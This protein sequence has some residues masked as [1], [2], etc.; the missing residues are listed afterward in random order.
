MGDSTALFMCENSL[1]IDVPFGG[2]WLASGGAVALSGSAYVNGDQ[3]RPVKWKRQREF[4][5][6]RLSEIDRLK[7]CQ[8]VNMIFVE[9][10]VSAPCFLLPSQSHRPTVRNVTV[11]L[12]YTCHFD[13]ADAQA[14]LWIGIYGEVVH[15]RMLGKL[16]REFIA[17]S[18][19]RSFQPGDFL[20]IDFG[21]PAC[22]WGVLVLSEKVGAKVWR[23]AL[24]SLL[25]D[26]IDIAG[27]VI[28]STDTATLD[29]HVATFRR[30][31][32]TITSVNDCKLIT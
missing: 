2:S 22:Q 27:S 12:R 9:P 1:A 28:F 10:T 30:E 21:S 16:N 13:T 26:S 5:M 31:L 3:S 19:T 32:G 11:S 18:R 24:Y 6:G 25:G 20:R 7:Y 15:E 14:S 4:G 17:K 8:S 23:S 29:G